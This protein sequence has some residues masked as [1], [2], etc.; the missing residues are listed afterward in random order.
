MQAVLVRGLKALSP[1]YA[2]VVEASGEI[3]DSAEEA[4]QGVLVPFW[5]FL[6]ALDGIISVL[7]TKSGKEFPDASI[8]KSLESVDLPAAATKTSKTLR[9]I[10]DWAESLRDTITKYDESIADKFQNL[11]DEALQ[12]A[13]GL[14]DLLLPENKDSDREHALLEEYLILSGIKSNRETL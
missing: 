3:E 11:R 12:V 4:N 1:L 13:M 7:E 2:G 10:S 6:E 14:E 8:K 5:H 9:K